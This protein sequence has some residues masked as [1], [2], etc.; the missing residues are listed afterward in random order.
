MLSGRFQQL[1]PIV[2]QL[3]F[4]AGGAPNKAILCTNDGVVS[5]RVAA[6]NELEVIGIRHHLDEAVLAHIRQIAVLVIELQLAVLIHPEVAILLLGADELGLVAVVDANLEALR[7]A[8][9]C[10]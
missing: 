10:V 6:D 8:V 4:L 2:R 1:L 7:Q 5:G 9:R 3:N